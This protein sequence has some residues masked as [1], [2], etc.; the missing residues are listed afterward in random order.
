MNAGRRGRW[1]E[2]ILMIFIIAA[3]VY[4]MHFWRINGYLP[5]PFVYDAND[6]F[7]DWFYTSYWAHNR[8]AYDVWRS[9][10]PPISFVFLWLFTTPQCYYAH[11]F[12]SRNCDTYAIVSILTFFLLAFAISAYA[13]WKNDRETALPRAICIGLG[14]PLLFTLERGNLILVAFI[15]F[16]LAHGQIVRSPI[17]RAFCIAIT[18]NFKTYLL[19]PTF[20]YAALRR[21][22]FMEVAGLF[23]VAVYLATLAIFGSG[24]VFVLAKNISDW[25]VIT[26]IYVWDFVYYSTSYA[27]YLWFDLRQFPVR[28]FLGSEIVDT[29]MF[30]VPIVIRIS[31]LLS[32]LA[33]GA[34]WTSPGTVSVQRVGALALLASFV[35]QNPGGYALVFPIFLIMFEKFE[36]PGQIVAIVMAYLMS[37]PADIPLDQFGNVYQVSKSV[38]LS[39]RDITSGFSVAL[40]S[41]FRPLL[42]VIMAW[43]LAL[44]T[45]Y[46]VIKSGTW[47]RPVFGLGGFGHPGADMTRA[48]A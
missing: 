11:P 4:D 45:L 24:S 34:A 47:R 31:Q 7:M 43:A 35:I 8:G 16:V 44:D 39:Q 40:G 33:L 29:I 2:A 15:F 9:V 22:R 27:P 1:I 38:W 17:V 14:L 42:V 30:L 19:F 46:V 6:T 23:T 37:I 13:L 36:R 5:P 48:A 10:Y 21:W 18:I 20:A 41:A 12:D 28:D 3:V 26:V 32:V 25:L